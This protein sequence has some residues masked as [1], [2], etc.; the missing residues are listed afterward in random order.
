MHIKIAL[1]V[2]AVLFAGCVL[3]PKETPHQ[4]QLTGD[5]V[6]LTGV[7]AQPAADGWWDSFQDPQL[8]RLIRL[9]LNDSPTLAQAQ[10][11]VGDALAQAQ[12][13]QAGLKPTLSSRR[14]SRATASGWVRPAPV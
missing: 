6:G 3:P 4:P 9:G 10:A 11:R 5:R 8:D 1:L 13:M 14:R 2:S 7:A 12:S